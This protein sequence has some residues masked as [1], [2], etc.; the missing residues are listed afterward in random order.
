M[1]L[2]ISAITMKPATCKEL[3]CNP[4][5][6]QK[7]NLKKQSTTIERGIVF[8]NKTMTFAL[9]RKWNIS[10]EG[11]FELRIGQKE[12]GHLVSKQE[13]VAS[14]SAYSAVMEHSKKS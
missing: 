6:T 8:R 12:E 9:I 7:E 1:K 3:F 4:E 11:I 2:A 14:R 13:N 5:H 10:R